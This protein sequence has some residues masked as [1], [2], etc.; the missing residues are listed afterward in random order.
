MHGII[1]NAKKLSIAYQI[2][3]AKQNKI[4]LLIL[5]QEK[6]NYILNL[7]TA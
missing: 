3:F 1:V 2:N 7:E 6:T 5:Y 4:N